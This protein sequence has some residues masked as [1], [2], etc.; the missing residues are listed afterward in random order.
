MQSNA[1]VPQ[2]G[3]IIR[4]SHQLQ[5]NVVNNSWKKAQKYEQKDDK[6]LANKM[7]KMNKAEALKD[8]QQEVN[9]A[10]REQ[11][12]S[13][14]LHIKI[15]DPQS[16]SK[17]KENHNQL[18]IKNEMKNN[19][20]QKYIEVYDTPMPHEPFL[21]WFGHNGLTLQSIEVLNGDFVFPPMIHPNIIK[22]FQF[23]RMDEE[24]KKQLKLIYVHHKKII[25]VSGDKGANEYPR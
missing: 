17:V 24:I 1:C 5:N 3:K 23:L 8:A 20:K 15:Q 9:S 25:T 13:N 21:S 10:L 19:F 12:S 14:I 2:H 18:E 4:K 16:P 7:R 6:Q 11:G 22:F